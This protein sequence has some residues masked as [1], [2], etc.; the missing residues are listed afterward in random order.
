MTHETFHWNQNQTKLFG[1]YWQIENPKGIIALV[2]GMGEHSGRYADF[3]VPQLNAAGYSVIA[4]DH[5][6]HGKT[7]GKRGHCP[8][9][10]AVLDSVDNLLKK[11]D[12]VFDPAL[13]LFLY[14]HSMGGNVVSNYI[15]KRKSRIKGAIITSP[16][17]K[18]AFNPPTWKLIAG[19]FMRNIY[20]AFQEATGLEAT[21][22]SRNTKA[23]EKYINDPLV[24]DKITINF[25][26]P[27]F[28]AGEYAIKNASKISVPAFVIHGTADAITAYKGSE[29]F[30]NNSAGK[31]SLKLYKDGFHELH[32]EPNQKEVLGDIITWLNSQL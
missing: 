8:S 10:N 12:E 20:P 18:L 26:L 16:M 29:S 31:A 21:A 30:V 15:I 4:F 17:L 24:H 5:F 13:P 2:H 23:V 19:K 28:E 7:E 25:S 1:Q 22:I 27:F 6:G 3:V 32:N 11:A 14:G 9:Y